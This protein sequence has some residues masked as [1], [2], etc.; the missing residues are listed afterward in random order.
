MDFTF[1][2]CCGQ[3][4][5]AA[6]EAVAGV[7]GILYGGLVWVLTAPLLSQLLDN[8]LWSP[9]T[10]VR[11]QD[12]ITGSCFCFGLVP[13]FARSFFT[14]LPPCFTLITLFFKQRSNL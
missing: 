11:K 13:A 12:G 5:D 3:C 1:F 10:D 9:A 6:D 2:L 4:C 7:A 8:V 14:L